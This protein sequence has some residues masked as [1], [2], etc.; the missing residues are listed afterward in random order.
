MLSW[1]QPLR[2]K[3]YLIRV[4]ILFLFLVPLA[5][6]SQKTI[7]TSV[8]SNSKDSTIQ[9]YQ[10][11]K[12]NQYELGV[13]VGMPIITGDVSPRPGYAGGISVRKAINHAFSL[14]GEYTGGVYY[15]TNYRLGIPNQ[16]ARNI[17]NN[18]YFDFY[19]PQGNKDY[20]ASYKTTMHQFSAQGVLSFNTWSI[21]RGHPLRNWYGFA[22]YSLLLAEVKVD[23]L[24]KDGRP[25]D[26]TNATRPVDFINGTRRQIRQQLRD[27]L[28]FKFESMGGVLNGTRTNIGVFGDNILRHSISGG[29]GYA[30]KINDKFNMAAEYRLT[31]GFSDDLDAIYKGRTHDMLHY[32]S[33]RFNFNI[34]NKAKKVEPLWWINPNV[35]KATETNMLIKTLVSNA[36]DSLD[37]DGDGVLDYRDKEKI[38]LQKC[39][40]V[41][42]DGVGTC[43]PVECC[44]DTIRLTD[45]TIVTR[46]NGCDIGMLKFSFAEKSKLLTSEMKSSLDDLA[47]R[48]RSNPNCNLIIRGAMKYSELDRVA[49]VRNYLTETASISE[50]RIVSVAYT[51][52][53]MKQLDMNTVQIIGTFNEK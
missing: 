46:K 8:S 31:F 6:I 41:D 33:L 9:S 45:S 29:G 22:G 5:G 21:H 32:F 30:Y 34:G 11:K 52:E 27:Y 38:T 14:R 17:E 50:T 42:E 2:E 40:P 48:L 39:F 36:L 20:L 18:P 25:Y 24:D 53:E 3:K 16:F 51:R 26:F 23:A 1:P 37:T 12:D 15:G 28:D 35:M 10:K 19:F 43:P 49:V 7:E 44:K 4:S 47:Q 13:H